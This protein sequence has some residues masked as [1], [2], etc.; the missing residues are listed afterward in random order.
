MRI[1]GDALDPADQEDLI[2]RMEHAVGRALEQSERVV[3]D[4]TGQHALGH[5][6]W[7]EG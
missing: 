3:E 6:E 1:E 2:T 4:G 5:R 7:I